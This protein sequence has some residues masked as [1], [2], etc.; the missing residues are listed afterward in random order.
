VSL[1]PVES[2]RIRETGG[3]G[4][5]YKR[6]TV[7]KKRGWTRWRD[8]YDTSRMKRDRGGGKTVS[9]RVGLKVRETML[10]R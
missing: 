3:K 1:N 6:R 8:M 10:F 5:T 9:E 2:E 4:K 7:K